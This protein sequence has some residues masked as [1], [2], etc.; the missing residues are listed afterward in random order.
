MSEIV[1]NTPDMTS[2][3]MAS[4]LKL[5]QPP[6]VDD[7][8]ADKKSRYTLLLEQIDSMYK[9]QYG[10][11]DFKP[12]TKGE[13]PM[14]LSTVKDDAPEIGERNDNNKEKNDLDAFG[15][16]KGKGKNTGK[17]NVCGGDGHYSGVAVSRTRT[18]R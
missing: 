5:D 15:K 4:Q 8:D 10:S 18:F 9:L 2:K 11:L 14:G 13:A 3:H 16:G 1:W 12:G 6:P 7:L 17:C